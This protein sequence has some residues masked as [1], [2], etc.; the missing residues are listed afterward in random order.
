VTQVSVPNGVNERPRQE[1][2]TGSFTVP[3]GEKWWG[4]IYVT[5]GPQSFEAIQINGVESQFDGTPQ[6]PLVVREGD[7][8]AAGGT[9]C[10]FSGYDVSAVVDNTIVSTQLATN[11]SISV[12]SG[13]TWHAQMIAA[14]TNGDIQLNGS[15]LFF[16]DGGFQIVL[17]GGDTI[18][19]DADSRIHIGAWV[20]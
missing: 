3:S 7:T 10:A 20:L 6:N 4:S 14:N 12:P 2:G 13:A 9:R 5:S 16:R 19:T 18:A 1:S 8:I 17:Q 11:S 15:D